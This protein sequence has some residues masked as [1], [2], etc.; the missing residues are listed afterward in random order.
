ML[1]NGEDTVNVAS[2][3][4]QNKL[5]RE[6]FDFENHLDHPT[7]ADFFNMDLSLKLDTMIQ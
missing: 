2:I 5:Y 6:L 4:V 7:A 3:A 1:E